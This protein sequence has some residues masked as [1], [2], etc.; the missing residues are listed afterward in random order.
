MWDPL[1]E[2]WMRENLKFPLTVVFIFLIVLNA[3]ETSTWLLAGPSPSSYTNSMTKYSS[4]KLNIG[5]GKNYRLDPWH[6]YVADCF[7]N[8]I[9]NAQFFSVMLLNKPVYW[10]F[11]KQDTPVLEKLLKAE[12]SDDVPL[13]S[14]SFVKNIVFLLVPDGLDWCIQCL[15][16]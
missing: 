9:Y 14:P 2:I 3:V 11:L 13:I 6:F 16:E 12:S 8:L 10:A 7:S 5:V 1:T 4:S 15:F